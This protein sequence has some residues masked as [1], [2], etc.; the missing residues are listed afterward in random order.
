MMALD[1][2]FT[3]PQKDIFEI[4]LCVGDIDTGEIID[5]LDIYVNIKYPLSEFIKE[6]C[7]CSDEDVR[8]GVAKED[9]AI[10]VNAFIKKHE[11][12]VCN[13]ITWGGDDARAIH[14]QF[15]D[16]T[17]PWHMGHR[18][19]DAKTLFQTLRIRQNQKLQAGLRKACNV[20]GHRFEGP[21]HNALKD[22]VATFHVYKKLLERFNATS[23][24]K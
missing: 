20:M 7:H 4:G 14:E 8:S 23:T 19:L 17:T 1:C 15:W 18:I 12:L 10:I 9:V 11:L 5:T 16:G 13:P 2:E 24:D 21:A 6:L 22:A 3:Q